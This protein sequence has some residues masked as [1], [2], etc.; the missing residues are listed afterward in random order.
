MA[1]FVKFMFILAC[2]PASLASLT[3]S[4]DAVKSGTGH[5]IEKVISLLKGLK[6]DAFAEGQNE[7]GVY[8]KFEL[9]CSNSLDALQSATADEKNQIVQ[10]SDLLDGKTAENATLTTELASLKEQLAE[11][12][13][14]SKSA[15]D[16]RANGSLQYGTKLAHLKDTIRAVDVAL[17]EMVTANGQTEFVQQ[18]ARNIVSLISLSSEVKVTGLQMSRL[19]ALAEPK[20]NTEKAREEARAKKEAERPNQTAAGD[21]EAH[22]DAYDFKSEQVVGLLK[23]L[24]TKFT[25]EK[26]ATTQEETNA[27]NEYELALLARNNV[28]VA[29]E[30]SDKRKTVKKA[31]A[32]AT[33]SET[34]NSLDNEREN[35]RVDSKTL[36]DTKN[37]CALKRQ[38]WQERSE[39]RSSEISAME[40]AVEILVEVSGVR[41]EPP[42]NPIPPAGP[43]NFIQ[44]DQFVSADDAGPGSSKMSAVTLL[45]EAAKKSHSKALE[46]LAVELK[47][48]IS[49]PFDQLNNMVEKMIFRLQDEQRREDEHKQ[50]CDHELDT[51]DAML[52]NQNEKHD[53]L[54]AHHRKEQAKVVMLS[55]DI[56]DINQ[57]IKNLMA[58]MAE[59][60]DVRTTGK[61]ENTLAIK[62]AAHA[63]EALGDAIAV[64]VSFYKESGQISKEPWE[65]IQESVSARL[66]EKP[67]TWPR[68]YTGVS[69]PTD[70]KSG[71][72]SV[73]EGV[74]SKFSAME[75]DTKAQEAVDQHKY[76]EAMS[77][78]NVE[79]ARLTTELEM[80]TREKGTKSQK[81]VS[82]MS[83]MKRTQAEIETSK[84]YLK[85]L[86]QACVDGD[87]SYKARKDARTEEIDALKKAQ[88]ILQNANEDKKKSASFLEIQRHA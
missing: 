42:E 85:R 1:I 35:L 87:S 25:K 65:F 10:L 79:K 9:W 22:V 59:A 82:L 72:V 13:A 53:D 69:N 8:Q 63:Q 26:L 58:F 6:A 20:G 27:Q 31:S 50:W 32:E 37:Q 38:E 62:D 11:L 64:L 30:H 71:I 24:R 78:S 36:E 47:A 5:P 14:S 80:K 48:H 84:G 34:Q 29:A 44:I 86:Q 52:E 7:A 88:G 23:D 17:R 21:H 2:M 4:R 81:M 19:Q 68:S 16:L 3:N 28:I 15:E 61:K 55:R 73:L 33:I 40:A 46:R 39:T 41:T 76:E 67:N 83:E 56:T 49:G 54:N 70:P 75:A 77:D 60:T 18:H 12:H 66:P 51:S 74:M 43:F 57:A 45:L